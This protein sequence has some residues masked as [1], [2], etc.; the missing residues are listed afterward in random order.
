[1][2][3]FILTLWAILMFRNEK[4][5]F[6]KIHLY[7]SETSEQSENNVDN[8]NNDKKS[9]IFCFFFSLRV[10]FFLQFKLNFY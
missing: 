9:I 10:I 7:I 2:D 3:D 8:N 4:D 6:W 1:M 5:A